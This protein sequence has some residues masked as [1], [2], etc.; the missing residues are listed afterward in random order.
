MAIFG[1]EHADL[2]LSAK[3]GGRIAELIGTRNLPAVIDLSEMLI[4][5]Q[6]EFMTDFAEG[7]FQVNRQ[8][9]HLIIDEADQFVP[10]NPLPET[11]RML[12]HIDRIVRRGRIR[13]FRVTSAYSTKRK[14]ASQPSSTWASSP[15]SV[16]GR[17]AEAH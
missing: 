2:P 14:S 17:R 1:G 11:R 10:Q 7:L 8:P 4:G 6:H 9:L 15:H 12:H 3:M 5:D 16:S 13:G